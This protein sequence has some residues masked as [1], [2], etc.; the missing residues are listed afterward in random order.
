MNIFLFL[1]SFIKK[2]RSVFVFFSSEHTHGVKQAKH[3]EKSG[4]FAIIFYQN[5]LNGVFS[6]GKIYSGIL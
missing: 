5:I 6:Y 4:D 1:Y 2:N 3:A